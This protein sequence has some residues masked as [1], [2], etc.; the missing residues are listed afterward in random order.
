MSTWEDAVSEGVNLALSRMKPEEL[1][2]LATDSY[3][4]IREEKKEH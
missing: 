1:Y 3:R 4:Q 2:E